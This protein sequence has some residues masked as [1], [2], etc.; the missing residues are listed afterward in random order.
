MKIAINTFPLIS[1]HKDRGIGFYTDN[2]IESL[3]KDSEIEIQEFIN[4]SEVKE[5]DIIHYPWFDFFFHNLPLRRKFKTVV[6]IHDVIPLLFP[7]EYPVGLKGKY[8]F[9]L[10]RLALRNCN[11]IIT[12]SNIC[13]LDIKK[14]FKIPDE[15]I[16]V[17][18]LA[19]DSNFKI[20]NDTNRIHIK[21]KY[22]LPNRFLLYVGDANWVKNLPFLIEGFNQISKLSEFKD[23]KLVLIGGVFLKKVENINHPELISIK[24]VNSLI[25]DLEIEEKIIRPGNIGLNELI[26]FYNLATIYIQPSVYEG[27]GLPLLEAFSCGVP[28]LSSRGGALSEIGGDAAVYFDSNNLNQFTSLLKDILQSKSLQDKLSKSGFKQVAKYSWRK[29]AHETKNIYSKVIRNG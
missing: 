17:V 25:K 27:F 1:G 14:V 23:V 26:S 5:A 18:H 11:Y 19:P 6:T 28:V 15:E 7:K 24:K 10:Q 4:L 8:N 20:V 13:K 16:S 9:F 22:N 21:K 29:V 2:L 12:D 3:K